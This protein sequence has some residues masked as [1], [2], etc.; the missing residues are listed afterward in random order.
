MNFSIEN[1]KIRMAII[2]FAVV[3]GII[4]FRIYKNISDNQQKAA[5]VSGAGS[6][7]VETA[8]V[9]RQDV[10]PELVFS[11]NLDPIW[12]AE[13]SPKFSGRLDRLYVDEGDIISAGQVL[14]QMD[15]AELAS[16][17]YQAEGALY[18]AQA[19]R[20]DAVANYERNAKLYEQ[21]AVSKKEYESSRFK[22]DN[23]S[24]SY[25]AAQGGLKVLQER[26]DSATLRSPRAGVVTR[27]FLHEGYYVNSGT[28]IISVADTTELLAVADVGEGH[29]GSIYLG[30]PVDIRVAAYGD[31]IFRGKITRISPVAQLPARTFRV[32]IQI[33]NQNQRLKGGM[34]A[35]IAIHGQVRK[36]ALIIP[37]TA[38]VMREDQK[39]VYVIDQNNVVQQKLL[40]VGSINDGMVEVLS[41]LD[42]GDR[43]VISGQNRLRQGSKVTY[44]NSNSVSEGKP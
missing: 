37:Q 30:A 44:E 7:E 24:G 43:I 28:P 13:I 14:A 3:F 36:N 1:K 19:D 4:G 11:A 31:E 38:I 34:F 35:T 32:E 42:E 10:I 41:G 5:R 23:A 29:I 26:L 15:A 27:R 18:S 20:Q 21:G 39:T 12:S 8:V 22:Q 6:I 16:Q 25:S 40:E 33:A 9:G 17:I 2:V